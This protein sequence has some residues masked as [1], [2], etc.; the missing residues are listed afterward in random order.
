MS[1]SCMF[2]SSIFLILTITLA[3]NPLMA[4]IEVSGHLDLVGKKY[5]KE[6]DY[7]NRT[8]A[9]QNNFSAVHSRLFFDARVSENTSVFVQIYSTAYGYIDLHGAY[10]RLEKLLGT[11]LNLQVGRIPNTIGTWGARTY[12]PVNPLIGVPLVWN[13]HTTLDPANLGSS[14]SLTNLLALRDSRTQGG[15]PILYD[16]CWNGGVELYGSF[17]KFDFSLAALSGSVTKPLV[18]QAKE[19]PQGT[20]KLSLA[21]SPGFIIGASGFYGPY[22]HE[23][24]FPA[25]QIFDDGSTSK[26]YMN[27]GG[28]G[29]LYLAHGPF[30]I[31]SE[32]YYASWEYPNLPLLTAISGYAE[33]KYKF[34]TGWYAAGRFDLFEPGMVSVNNQDVNWDYPLKRYEYGIGYKPNRNLTVKA[35]SQLNRFADKPEFDFDHYAVQFALEF[36]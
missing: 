11:S 6:T 15:M 20:A 24:N 4:Q 14:P 13:H 36:R 28:G 18:E 5:Q 34:T 16:F 33:A 30:E 7:T 10:L 21:L 12:S 22:L 8:F 29:D 19:L 17:G 25:N 9:G 32:A 2:S 26:D 27:I 35:V 31:F 23:G 3:S 1:L